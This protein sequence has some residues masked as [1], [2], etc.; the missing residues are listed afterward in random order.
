MSTKLTVTGGAII[1]AGGLA[2][3]AYA[4]TTGPALAQAKA[5]AVNTYLGLSQAALAKNDRTG[6]EKMA[7][8]A[9]QSD[10]KSKTALAGLKKAILASCPVQ[11]TVTPSSAASQTTST[12]TTQS[13]PAQSAQPAAEDDEEMGCI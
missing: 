3:A 8:K 9:L 13:P 2:L 6:A 7:L 12:A 5:R 11:T 10:P 1:L 4:S